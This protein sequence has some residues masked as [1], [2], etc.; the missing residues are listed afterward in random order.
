[1]LPTIAI[2]SFEIPT[3]TLCTIIGILA[4]V[5]IIL[6]KLHKTNR[7]AQEAYFILPKLFIAFAFGFAG[8]VF[9]DALFKIP[10]NG[11]FK[12]AGI[13]FYG[14]V[15]TGIIALAILISVFQKNSTMTL[16]EWLNF[17][18]LPFIVFH[19]F[20][21]IGCFLGGCCYGLPTTSIFGL[22]FPDNP[23]AGIFHYGQKVYP[24]QLFEAIG[25]GLIIL[26]IRFSKH[27]F[28]TYCYCYPSLRFCVEFLRGDNRG[29]YL[30][31]FSPAQIISLIIIIAVTVYLFLSTF[32]RK[33]KKRLETRNLTHKDLMLIALSS[34]AYLIGDWLKSICVKSSHLLKKILSV[35]ALYLFLLFCCI[36][37]LFRRKDEKKHKNDF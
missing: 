27:K 17:S 6:Y 32:N 5:S 7:F 20:G 11:Y 29:S 37:S 25:L 3:F 10:Q 18:T 15:I 23:T 31:P 8:A 36:D 33:R 28:I 14:G 30:G 4:F 21:R 1:M 35:A 34:F 24:T 9:F 26:A 12:I 16:G 2:G 22:Y 13:T 19:F